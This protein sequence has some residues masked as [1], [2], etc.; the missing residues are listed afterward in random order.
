MQTGSEHTVKRALGVLTELWRRKVWRDARTVNVIA[1]ATLHESPTIMLAALKFFLGQD[2]ADEESDDEGDTD[3]G[4]T[5]PTKDDVYRAH[6][7][8]CMPARRRGRVAC[9][10]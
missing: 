8:V 4:P 10:L 5:A 9:A 3:A 7:K 6:H 1:S 2:T